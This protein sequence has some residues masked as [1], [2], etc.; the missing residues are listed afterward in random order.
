MSELYIMI[1]ICDRK[2][3]PR[4]VDYYSG[5]KIETGN[6]SLGMGTASDDI[7]D[8]LGLEEDEKGIHMAA[9]TANTWDAI[10]KGLENKLKIDVPGMG[11]VFTIPISSVGGKRELS[12]LVQEQEFV[13]GDES[14]LKDTTYELI[15]AIANYGY[16]T[17]VMKA[18]E[19]GGATG[20]TVLHGKGVGMK[21]AQQFLG[22]SLVSEKEIIL[23][24]TKAEEKNSIMKAIM[25]KAGV[26]TKAG[27]IVFSM[28]VTSV[29][30][31]R[32]LDES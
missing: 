11:I 23:I 27:A 10:K 14:I 18:A 22:V 15:V 5:N 30:G 24:V 29:A 28:P 2:K 1:T 17:Q 8:Y 20:G 12:F 31:L 13:K 16:N 32:I 9:V 26:D 7:L 21:H 3:L 6:I 19:E 25:Q 4:F